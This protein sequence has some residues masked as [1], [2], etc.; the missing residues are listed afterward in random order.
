LF[1]D[2]IPPHTPFYPGVIYGSVYSPIDAV[3]DVWS[4]YEPALLKLM[5]DCLK[6]L[7]VLVCD[8]LYCAYADIFF[9]GYQQQVDVVFRLHQARKVDFRKGK[10]LG[11]HHR[12]FIWDKP[13]QRPKGLAQH[14]YDQLPPTLF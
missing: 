5:C 11:K 7:S 3:F 12:V 1:T 6:P 13:K 14:V 8:R 4:A 2:V 9:W 10:R